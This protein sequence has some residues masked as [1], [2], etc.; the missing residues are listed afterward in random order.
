MN[1]KQRDI[2]VQLFKDSFV[3][4]TLTVVSCDLPQF[5]SEISKT[6]EKLTLMIKEMNEEIESGKYDNEI[7]RI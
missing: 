1:Q 4:D 7:T 2:I 5:F 6:D 3:Y